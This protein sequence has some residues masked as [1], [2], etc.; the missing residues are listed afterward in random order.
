M[1]D[2]AP[3]WSDLERFRFGDGPE[4][5]DTLLALVLSGDKTATCWPVREGQLTAIGKRMVA[6]DSQDRP[7]AVIETVSLEVTPFDQVT[8]A[9]A[10][11]EGEDDKTL[12]SWRREHQAY[13]ER[14]GGF[15]P[16]MPLWCETFRLIAGIAIP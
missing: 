2:A 16:A 8:E 10:A 7:R 15:D 5:A 11:S 4:T 13:F 3:Y 9:F 1:T 6:C 14:N 12:A